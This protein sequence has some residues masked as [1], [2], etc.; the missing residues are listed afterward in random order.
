MYREAA[1]GESVRK[2]FEEFNTTADRECRNRGSL[3]VYGVQR[4]FNQSE[5]RELSRLEACYLG[6]QDSRLSNQA[7]Q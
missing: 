6:C 5:P 7:V 1:S 2:E 4:L 3:F